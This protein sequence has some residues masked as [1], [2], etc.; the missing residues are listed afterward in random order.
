MEPIISCRLTDTGIWSYQFWSGREYA[1]KVSS[2]LSSLSSTARIEA[3][4]FSWYSTFHVDT[5]V[6]P[7]V[8][9]KV[10]DDRTG[11]E[12]FRIIFCEPGFYRLMGPERSLLVEC[13]DGAYLFGN[14]GQPVLALTERISEWPWVPAGEPYFRTTVYEEDVRAE[15]LTGMLAFPA[16]RF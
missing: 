11:L 6:F 3:G 4:P 10:M 12:I 8:S 16:L 7:G 2:V 5:Q 14:P 1:G 9:R 15:L 13:R